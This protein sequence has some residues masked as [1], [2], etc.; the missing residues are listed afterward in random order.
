[1]S[2]Y[3][4]KDKQ[5]YIYYVRVAGHSANL[6]LYFARATNASLPTHRTHSCCYEHG[7]EHEHNPFRALTLTTNKQT[8][9]NIHHAATNMG[10]NTSTTHFVR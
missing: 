10:V 2:L 1:M 6:C 8:Q 5:I 7:S 9:T 3:M 4:Y